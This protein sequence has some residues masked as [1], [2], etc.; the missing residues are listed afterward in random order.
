MQIAFLS[1][2]N[3]IEAKTLSEH[4]NQ[5]ITDLW[6]EWLRVAYKG[7]GLEMNNLVEAF[8][9]L[10]RES[11]KAF[12]HFGLHFLREMLLFKVNSLH[13]IRLLE[14]EAKALRKL[15]SLVN[16]QAIEKMISMVEQ[17]IFH[18]ERN[19]N[20]KI[21]LLDSSIRMHYILR[22]QE[23]RLAAMLSA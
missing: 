13:K 12:M 22:N 11:Q 7:F 8:V 5:K 9:K 15:N 14:G 2:G 6:L 18:L 3:L 10:N 16:N 19:I 4:A 21:L 23:H 1:E 17:N 20:S